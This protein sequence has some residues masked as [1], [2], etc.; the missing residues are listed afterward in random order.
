VWATPTLDIQIGDLTEEDEIRTL[1]R[2]GG[3]PPGFNPVFAFAPLTAEELAALRAE[4]RAMAE[5]MGVVAATAEMATVHD[6]SWVYA[7]TGY[8][9]FGQE[10]PPHL[11]GDATSA[12]LRGASGLVRITV[13]P[14][15]EWQFVQRVTTDDRTEWEDEKRTGG[16]RDPRLNVTTRAAD[17]T[18]RVGLAEAFDTM[19]RSTTLKGWVFK[20]P[21]AIK[22]VLQGIVSSGLDIPAYA[23]HWRANSGASP[24]S[25]ISIEIVNLLTVLF[26][27]ISYDQYDLLNSASAEAISRRIL[28]IQRAVKRNPKSPDFSGL[29][30]F[31]THTLD[32]TAGLTTTDFD[33]YISEVQRAEAQVM[34]QQRLQREETDAH[35]KRK[36]QKSE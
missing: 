1:V 26:L 29:E 4:A 32:H 27:M 35:S 30:C 20:G 17:G 8:D 10:V 22:E 14:T 23:N 3:F 2:G 31:V 5:V 11:L 21:P 16:G 19:L 36:N 15:E 9:K 33:K 34:K 13:A 18:P 7:D 6:S 24:A 28:Q 12:L 25:A